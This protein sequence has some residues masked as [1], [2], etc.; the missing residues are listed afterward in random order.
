MFGAIAKKIF[1]TRNDRLVKDAFK[2]VKQIN[3]LEPTMQA[4]SDEELKQQTVKFRER[5]QEGTSLNKLLPEAFATIREASTR[6]LGLRHYDVQMI[7]GITLHQGRIAE[8]RTGEGKTLVA[9]LAVYLNALEGKGVHVVTVNDYLAKRDATDMGRLYQWMGLSVG[10]I[11]SEQ[12]PEEKKAA[13]ECDITYCTNNEIGFDYL[14]DNMSF[15]PEQKV[16]RPLN[17]AVIDEVDSILIDEART[18][19]II[20][21][22]A[23]GTAELYQAI[24]LVVPHL[25]KADENGD[26]DFTINEKDRQVLLT[27]IGHEHAEELLV[28]AGLLKEGESLYDANN[29]KLYHHLDSCLR[30]H[31]LFRKDVDYLIKEGEIIIVDEHTGRTLSG[32]RWSDGLHQAIEAKEGVQIKPENQTLASITFQNLFRIYEKLSGMTGTADTE[33][34]EL[35][36]IYGL[37]VVV[38]PTNRE[39]KR[40]DYGDLIFLTQREKYEA[41]IKDIVHCREAGQ[42]VLVGT[43]SVEV[44]ELIS[45][46]L[47]DRQIPHEVLNA[48]QHE[49]EAYIVGAAGQPGAVT[50]ATNMAGRGTDIV[51][52]GNFSMELE[53]HPDATEAEKAALKAEWQKRHDKVLTE[54]GLHIIGTER[55][56]SRRVDNQLRGRSGRQGDVGSSRFYLSLEDNLMRIFTSP[57]AY[58]MMKKLGMGDGIPLEHKWISRSIENAQR[59]VEGHH[60]E[61]RKNLLQYDNVANDQRKVIYQQRDDILAANDVGPAIDAIRETV[62]RDLVAKHIPPQSF[63]EQWDMEG[64]EEKLSRDFLMDVKLA[65]WLEEDQELDDQKVVD[66]L[67]EMNKQAYHSKQFVKLPDSEE[68]ISIVDQDNFKAFEKNI[69][70]QLLDHNW[71]DHLAAM[72]YLRQGIQLRAYAQKRPEQEYKKEA[73]SMFEQMLDRIYYD[74]IVYLSRLKIE[75]P[76]VSEEQEISLL[77]EDSNEADASE[78]LMK[79]TFS[80]AGEITGQEIDFSTV[81]RND[82]CPCGSG[83]KY[84]HCHGKLS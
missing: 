21:G 28:Q 13:Y 22:P 12:G 6:V 25:V 69:L 67:I 20:S 7:G 71:K 82:D 33:A 72:D 46:M 75:L 15:Q 66:R 43:A 19:L 48:K 9:T 47:D 59:K 58:N 51:L 61:M 11:V 62:F 78:L 1:G 27:E 44:S 31:H 70:L 73:F 39:I 65:A 42:P 57:S 32:R 23:E 53:S 3:A 80:D 36:E 26:N 54:G 84:K 83:K 49:R 10:V 74:T 50:I 4:M 38:I 34:P 35:L 18:P 5:I 81:G 60:F 14:R 79:R 56:E 37:E 55:H 8:M 41:I 2:I 63:P 24:N 64:L 68:E 77:P 76:T 52:G 30:A 17:F 29:L 16:Q 45:Q 40:K